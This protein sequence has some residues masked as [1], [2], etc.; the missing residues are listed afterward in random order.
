VT[1]G[2]DVCT[3]ADATRT[4]AWI[5]ARLRTQRYPRSYFMVCKSIVLLFLVVS[6]NAVSFI[7][8]FTEV[9]LAIAA[10]LPQ[11]SFSRT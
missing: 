8:I 11:S 10:H 1:L 3:E 5:V 7:F 6:F 4:M 2:R 9:V